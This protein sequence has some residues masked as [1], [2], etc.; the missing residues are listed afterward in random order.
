M[1]IKQSHQV[2]ED[3]H[4]LPDLFENKRVSEGDLPKL[5]HSLHLSMQVQFKSL[6]FDVGEK[7]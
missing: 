7:E 2:C 4:L 6:V 1:R 3:N 5:W